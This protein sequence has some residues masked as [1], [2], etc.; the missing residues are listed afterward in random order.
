MKVRLLI[1]Q[2]LYVLTWDASNPQF[3]SL[4]YF[5]DFGEETARRFGDLPRTLLNMDSLL[6]Y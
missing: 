2:G 1:K 6:I 3:V 5:A 4:K